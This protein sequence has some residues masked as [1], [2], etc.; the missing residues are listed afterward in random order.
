MAQDRRGFA[1]RS[2]EPTGSPLDPGVRR[3]LEHGLGT[4]LS[5]VRVHTGPEVDSLLGRWGGSAATMGCDIWMSSV[6][7]EGTDAWL[8]VL[9]HESAHVVQQ[10]GGVGAGRVGVGRV[11]SAWERAA[12]VSAKLVLGGIGPPAGL[13]LPEPRRDR[14]SRFIQRFNSWEHRLLGDV[15][16]QDLVVIATKA[17]GWAQVVQRQIRYLELWVNGTAGITVESIHAVLPDLLVVTLRNG[18]LATYGELNAVGGDYAVD[19]TALNDLPTAIMT[20]FL[21]QVR[22]ESL[23]RLRELLGQTEPVNFTQAI[24]DYKGESEIGLLTETRAI[25]AFTSSLGLNHYYGLLARN[26]CHFAPFGWTRWREFHATATSLATSAYSATDPTTKAQLTQEAWVTQAYADHFIEDSFAAGH[27]V[28]KTLIM[29]WFTDWA[30]GQRLLPVPAWDLVKQVDVARQPGLMGTALY[31]RGYAG[32][33]NDPQSAEEQAT[34]A[35]RMAATGVVASGGQT[36]GEGYA[37]YLAFLEAAVVQLSSNQVHNYFNENSLTVTSHAHS[38]PFVVYGDEHLLLDGAGIAIPAA[39]VA[40][41]KKIIADILATG[42]ST[43]GPQDVL[44]QLPSAVQAGPG[45]VPLLQWHDQTLRQSCETKMFGGYKSY[46]TF[47]GSS[48]GLVS[49]D[50]NSTGFSTRWSTSLPGCGYN[51]VSTVYDGQHL[52]AGSN[53]HVYVMRADNGS[54][55]GSNGLPGL[56][57]NEIRLASDGSRGYLGTNGYA[58][59]INLGTAGTLWETS[60]PGSGYHAVSLLAAQNGEVYAGSW[61]NVYRLDP[62]SG[63]VLGR[64]S[65]SGRGYADISL[66]VSLAVVCVGTNGYVLGLDADNLSTLWQTSLPGCGYTDV[67]VLATGAWLIAGS[68]GYVYVLDPTSGQVKWTN[69]LSGR[70]YHEIGLVSDGTTV[71]VGTSGHVIAFTID[72]LSQLW[73]VSLS[74]SMGAVVSLELEGAALFVG[75]NGYLYQLDPVTGRTMYTNS[76]SGYGLNNTSTSSDGQ[77]LFVGIDGYVVGLGIDPV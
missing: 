15:S 43:T 36:Q 28:N 34:Y 64:N 20:G 9:A 41:S 62:S 14:P 49:Q 39:A 35:A 24:T 31:A 61:G 71:Y 19:P 75:V 51:D 2:G 17:D 3:V 59:G 12:D 70:G 76:L 1:G 5:T 73:D 77:T 52:L 30:A 18:C 65:L 55:L 56:G 10:A 57:Y 29:Q 47:F 32:P 66:D 74:A 16:S 8:R 42:T 60:L 53:G 72:G 37:E 63:A 6:L 4:D 22:Q 40:S 23:N 58:L 50:Q 25:E 13:T 44:D 46:L 48:M 69:S 45:T 21:Q 54:V 7:P 38:S 68:N 67:T 27:L 33:S 26:A 11:G